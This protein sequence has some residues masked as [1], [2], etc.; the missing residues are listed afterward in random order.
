YPNIFRYGLIIKNLAEP[1]K[2]I[3]KPVA[4]AFCDDEDEFEPTSSKDISASTIRVRMQARREHEKALAEDATI[5]DYDNIYDEL[6]A[7]K[8]EKI[9][10]IKA[11]DKDRKSKYAEQ[12]LETHK[13]RVLAQQSREERKQQKER[14]AE[15]GKFDDKE[16]FV[17]SSYRKQLIEMESFRLKEAV[18]NQLTAVEKQK[19]GMWASGFYRTLLNDISRD[20]SEVKTEVKDLKQKVC[21]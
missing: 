19:S 20:N 18:D 4:A 7:K 21:D 13:K 15:A 10:E 6:Q 3:I 8:N 14:E 16:K 2:Q 17:T 5:F 12:I 9:A 11:A 1:S